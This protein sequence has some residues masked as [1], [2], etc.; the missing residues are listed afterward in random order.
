MTLYLQFLYKKYCLKC[1]GDKKTECIVARDDRHHQR[2]TLK[3]DAPV[4]AMQAYEEVSVGVIYRCSGTKLNYKYQS[5]WTF[6]TVETYNSVL[7]S[8][9]KELPCSLNISQFNLPDILISQFCIHVIDPE[10]FTPA[11]GS[12][13]P[14]FQRLV[15]AR[16][17]EV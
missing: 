13:Q 2:V 17:G 16:V 4:N 12:T 8:N 5:Y 15:G 1:V 14:P 7:A 6:V 3:C 10:V 11:L 9:H